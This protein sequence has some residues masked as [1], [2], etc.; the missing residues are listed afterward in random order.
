MKVLAGEV[1]YGETSGADEI[2]DVAMGVCGKV[3]VLGEVE[4]GEKVQEFSGRFGV[5]IVNV[6]IEVTKKEY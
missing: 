5:F 3:Y 1:V 4:A 2:E 6:E